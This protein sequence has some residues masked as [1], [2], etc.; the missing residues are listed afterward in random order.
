MESSK[1]DE[2]ELLNIFLAGENSFYP[3]ATEPLIYGDYVIATDGFS[4]VFIKE[5]I[6]NGIYKRFNRRLNEYAES[7]YSH[8]ITIEEIKKA[9]DR[10]PT[11]A[12]V[13]NE[14]EEIECPECNGSG[15]VTWEYYDNYNHFHTMDYNCPI[16]N[17]LG[18]I[19]SN[20][21][22]VDENKVKDEF[23]LIGF[24]PIIISV[25]DA[26]KLYNAMAIIGIDTC[27]IIGYTSSNATFRLNKDIFVVITKSFRNEK[28]FRIF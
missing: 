9:I 5:S 22:I 6:T 19:D 15:M 23:S 25:E 10:V 24:G 27:E 4:A 1:F 17:G 20:N 16:C 18:I 11:L 13:K 21:C 26:M 12:T 28:V 8:I 7:G 14:D 3:F 2:S